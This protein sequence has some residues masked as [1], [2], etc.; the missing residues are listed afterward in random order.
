VGT[1]D[2]AKEMGAQLDVPRTAFVGMLG[3]M[4]AAARA[5]GLII[6]DGVFNDLNDM[7]GF[8]TQLRQ[9]VAFGFDGKTLIHPSQIGPC[10]KIFTPNEQAVAWAK[11]VIEAFNDPANANKGA[12]RLDGQM[13]ERLHLHQA[14]KTIA[15]IS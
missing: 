8:E 11:R 15:T 7:D 6:L 14:K 13:V 3:L 5:H 12:I 10:N 2:L 1:N 4:V 9:S